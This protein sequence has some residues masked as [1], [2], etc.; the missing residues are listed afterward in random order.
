MAGNNYRSIRMPYP[1]RGAT[2]SNHFSADNLKCPGDDARLDLTDVFVFKSS[3]NP[4]QTVLIIDSNPFMTGPD[5][6]PEAVYRI[7]VDTDGDAHADVAF[8][9]TFSELKNGAQTGT[10]Y[11]ATGLQAR[12]PEPFGEVLVSSIPVGFDAGAQPVQVGA[13]RLFVGVP[14]HP[15]FPHPPAALPEFHRTRPST[16]AA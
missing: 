2:M 4:D 7:N 14:R 5:F 9:F 1:I 8:T 6:H 13:M 16:S 11:H 15:F 10:A 3:D 12:Q